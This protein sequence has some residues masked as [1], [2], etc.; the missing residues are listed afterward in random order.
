MELDRAYVING[1][2][3]HIALAGMNGRWPAVPNPRTM[4]A[5]I[6]EVIAQPLG[7]AGVHVTGKQLAAVL[8]GF[9]LGVHSSLDDVTQGLVAAPVHVADAILRRLS[10][11]AAHEPCGDVV[12]ASI[13][14][15]HEHFPDDRELALMAAILAGMKQLD[16]DAQQRI[17]NW[18]DERFVRPIGPF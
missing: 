6:L 1:D 15:D 10:A 17:R 16:R 11:N 5:D 12:D 9:C 14:C 13:C 4:A 3:L 2:D 8:D 7:T 18:V